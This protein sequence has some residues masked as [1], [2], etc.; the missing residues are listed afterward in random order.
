MRIRHVEPP[1]N[2]GGSSLYFA[3]FADEDDDGDDATLDFQRTPMA[4]QHRPRGNAARASDADSVPYSVQSGGGPPARPHAG[5][6]FTTHRRLPQRD[7]GGDDGTT[8]AGIA[9]VISFQLREAA[10]TACAKLVSVAQVALS[11]RSS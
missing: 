7:A 11:L 9:S 8:E 6:H 1:L 10:K 2:G 3:S 4:L 5:G